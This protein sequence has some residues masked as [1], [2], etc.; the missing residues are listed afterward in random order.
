[1]VTIRLAKN[2]DFEF[3]FKLKSEDFNIFWAGG[4]DK[5]ERKNLEKFFYGAVKNAALKEKR[6]IYI[7]ENELN[8]KVG[9]LYINPDGSDYELA[10]AICSE[11]CGKGYAKLAIKAGLAEGE[12]LG[13]KRMVSYIRE[14]NI[15]SMKA[16]GSCGVNITDEFKEVYIPGLEKNVKMFKIIYENGEKN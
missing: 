9:H 7:I 5:P 3:F 4:A 8:K 6:K 13:F 10:C 11:F 12:R 1:M 16:Y 2:D 15:A 14:D